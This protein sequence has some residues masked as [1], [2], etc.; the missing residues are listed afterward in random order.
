MIFLKEMN[1]FNKNVTHFKETNIFQSVLW[2]L[3]L[4]DNPTI[5]HI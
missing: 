2:D 3:Y 1:K 5:L 4:I